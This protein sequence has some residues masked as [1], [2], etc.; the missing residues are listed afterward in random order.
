MPR[1]LCGRGLSWIAPTS[2]VLAALSGLMIHLLFYQQTSFLLEGLA[3][4]S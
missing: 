3:S 2:K 1:H 4:Q